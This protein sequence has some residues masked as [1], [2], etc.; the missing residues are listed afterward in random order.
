MTAVAPPRRATPSA[1]PKKPRPSIPLIVGIIAAIGITIWAGI[2]IEF[3]LLPLIT[4]IGRGAPIIEGFLA[5]NWGFTFRVWDAWVETLSIAVLAS[6][7]GCGIALVLS[8]LASKVTAR[9][10]IVFR[11]SRFV[12]S[13][14][15]SL[16]DI[17]YGL[18]FVAAVGIGSLAGTLALIMF[19]IGVCAKLTSET[20]DGIDPGPLEAA[21]ASGAGVFQRSR[22]A[23]LP[24]ILPSYFSYSF[25]VFEL[26]IRASV[27]IGLVGGGGIG[28]VIRV[29]MGRFSYE[30]LSAIIITLFVIVF[31][32]DVASRAIR[33]RLI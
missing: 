18:I 9:N 8:F 14:I 3:T 28:Q 16:P 7:V 23:V 2:G 22:S 30:N 26:N 24:Q 29:Q 27:V 12:L 15:R 20:I 6:L 31:A 21:D 4:D 17:A 33:R 1:R 5:P 13:L 25:Y 19:N 11:V 32:L 10:P